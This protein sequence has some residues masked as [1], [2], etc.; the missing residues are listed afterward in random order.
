MSVSS[1]V[2][3]EHREYWAEVAKKNGWY[4]EPFYVH[5]WVDKDGFVEDSVSYQ[6]MTEDIIIKE[7]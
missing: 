6:G 7:E 3:D 5:V 1:M 4:K 2:V